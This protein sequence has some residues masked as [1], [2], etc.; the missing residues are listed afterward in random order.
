MVSVVLALLLQSPTTVTPDR[1]DVTYRVGQTVGWTVQSPA[2]ADYSYTL[3]AFNH[4]EV[5]SGRISVGQTPVRIEHTSAE[6]ATLILRLTRDG[7]QYP[8]DFAAFVSPERIR[9]AA[10]RP[11]D[12]D[13]FWRTKLQELKAVPADPVWE[14][15]ASPIPGVE[16]GLVTMNHV[17][18]TKV[19]G[20]F[21][22]PARPGRFP[23]I[24]QLQWASPPYPLD[25]NWILYRAAQGF[26]IL[27]IQPHD[28][29]AVEAPAY[30]SALSDRLKNYTANGANYFV[31]MYLRGVR[32]ADWLTQRPDWDGRT[33]VVTGASMGGQ[34]SFAVAALHPKATHLMATVPAGA[35]LTGPRSG[36]QASYPYLTEDPLSPS[37][38]AA[39]FAPAIRAR[40]LVSMGGIDWTCPPGGIWAAFNL[41]PGPKEAVPMPIGPHVA[42]SPEQHRPWTERSEH[43]FREIAAGRD[44]IQPPK[45]RQANQT[46]IAAP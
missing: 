15:K 33:L 35:E 11:A 22:K 21:A 13:G 45:A 14:P 41:I 16:Y 1:A 12:F 26:M 29:R 8:L 46:V 9:P 20:Q 36:R 40:S 42:T 17:N 23:A 2:P 6:P 38:D 28:V 39:N 31:E 27:N 44:P 7:S 43:W 24:L 18:G 30:Y 37:I 5:K 25:P 10:P 19:Y 4:R 32:A 34:Q 3:L